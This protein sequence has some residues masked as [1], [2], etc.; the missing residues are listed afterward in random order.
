[1]DK[2]SS[3]FF[4]FLS[5]G[6][7]LL[8]LLASPA[9]D[10]CGDS[11]GIVQ[12]QTAEGDAYTNDC[13]KKV[14]GAW[15]FSGSQTG[16]GTLSISEYRQVYAVVQPTCPGM[17]VK[18]Q[19]SWSKTEIN[20]VIIYYTVVCLGKEYSYKLTLSFDPNSCDRMS[21]TKAGLYK[22]GITETVTLSKNPAGS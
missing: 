6:V 14:Q 12:N 21:G 11:G 8:L 16:S 17:T 5:R 15:S 20:S 19:D 22:D 10:S 9:C 2:K 1:M 3:R 4:T 7:L 18:N 13:F